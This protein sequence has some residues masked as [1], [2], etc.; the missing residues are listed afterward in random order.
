METADGLLQHI[1]ARGERLTIQRRLVIDALCKQP[2][3]RSVAELEAMTHLPEPTIYRILQWLK[4]LELVS[5]TDMGEQGIVYELVSSPPHHHLICLNCG[6][7]IDVPDDLFVELRKQLRRDYQF[8]ARI[9]HMAMY[10][11]CKSCGND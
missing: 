7:T 5:Q 2:G 1:Q 4:E 3:H 10:G 6:K 9:E 8:Q 11:W